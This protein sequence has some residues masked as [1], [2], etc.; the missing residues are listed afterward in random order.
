ML[1]LLMDALPFFLFIRLGFFIHP[2]VEVCQLTLKLFIAGKPAFFHCSI[3]Y[4]A[5]DSAAWLILM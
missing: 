2:S 4:A 3:L 5:Q 1:Y